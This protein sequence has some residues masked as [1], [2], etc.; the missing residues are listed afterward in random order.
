MANTL[1]CFSAVLLLHSPLP[2]LQPHLAAS[3]SFSNLFCARESRDQGITPH[4]P[5]RRAFPEL[6]AGT[7]ISVVEWA[8]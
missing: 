5:D 6:L 2:W 8:K 4:G 1:K 3:H 7:K